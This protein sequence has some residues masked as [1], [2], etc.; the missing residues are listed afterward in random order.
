[1]DELYVI[2]SAL[3]YDVSGVKEVGRLEVGSG[4]LE[5]VVVLV[6]CMVG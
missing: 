4:V 5:I 2:E 3:V 1:M 6:C